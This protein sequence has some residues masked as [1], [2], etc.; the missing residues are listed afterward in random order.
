[1]NDACDEQL[2]LMN[3]HHIDKAEPPIMM[4]VKVCGQMLLMQVDTGAVCTVAPKS[5]WMNLGK[6]TLKEM[7]HPLRGYNGAIHTLG[8]CKLD[9]EVNGIQK[10]A[11][12]VIVDGAG[13]ILMGRDWIKLFN[14]SVD[15]LLNSDQ[16]VL[17]VGDDK[18]TI[19]LQ[20]L[21]EEFKDVFDDKPGKCDIQVQWKLKDDAK[22]RFMKARPVPYSIKKPVEEYLDQK[23]LDGRLKYVKSSDWASPIVVVPKPD[24]SARVCGDYKQTIN[25]AMESNRYPLPKIEDL[26]HALNGGKFFSKLDLADAFLQIP[27][28]EESKKFT[29][30][31]THKGLFQYQTMPPGAPSA[32]SDFQEVIDKVLNGIERTAAY[33]DDVTTSSTTVEEHLVILKKVFERLRKHGMKLKLKKCEFLKRRIEYLGHIVD[34]HGIRPNPK[35]I[36]SMVKMPPPKNLKELEAFLGM[37]N[38]YGKFIKNLSTLAS[39]LFELKK[40]DVEWSWKENH[41]QAFELIKERLVST[42]VLTH[43]DPTKS[44]CLSADASEY[45]LGAVIY[46]KLENGDEKVIAY[47]SR[48]LTSAEKN[49]A[50][51]EKEALAIIY[52]VE[53]FQIYLLG[54]KF[55]MFTDHQ[56]LLRIFGPKSGM[57]SIAIKRLARWAIILS[58]YDYEIIYRKGEEMGN[59]NGLSRLPLQNDDHEK[60]KLQE[61]KE[62]ANVSPLNK[63][64]IAEATQMDEELVQIWSWTQNGWPQKFDKKW[65]TWKSREHLLTTDVP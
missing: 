10:E 4:N 61:I 52:G 60:K 28:D 29:T 64:K 11:D 39:P 25:P 18:V 22:P 65:K 33:V 17:A 36:E 35:K 55:T 43:Y 47:A 24:K 34:E 6:P 51:V 15:D 58:N 56:P 32:T 5:T 63:K 37:V 20:E 48:T 44:I 12:L 16:K 54:R 26:F 41:E 13:D 9:V 38:Y 21:L 2:K 27:L 19:P 40:K 14:I 1:M 45:G 62:I 23:V 30:I 31:N 57:N 50:Q 46:H 49:Y 59:A 7:K 53:K 8:K 3:I 42:D